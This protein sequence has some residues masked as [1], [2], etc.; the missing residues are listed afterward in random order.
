MQPIPLLPKPKVLH[1][2]GGGHSKLYKD[3]ASGM[4]TPPVKDGKSSFWP[5]NECA[6]INAARI[7]GKSE[8]EIK[9]LVAD[10]VKR[11][12]QTMAVAA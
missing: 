1:V 12:H 4:W 11:R 8:A 10:L 9:A 2:K 6:E 5:E 3:I 7:A